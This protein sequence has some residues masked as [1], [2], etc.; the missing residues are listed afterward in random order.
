MLEQMD[1]RL[2]T[3]RDVVPTAEVHKAAFTR[4]K[5]SYEWIECNAKSCPQLQIF[6]AENENQEIVGYIHWCQKSGFRRQRSDSFKLADALSVNRFPLNCGTA[7]DI[8]TN[9]LD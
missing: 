4:Q 3:N 6:V 7:Q 9:R 2:F 8:L 5:M 1:I